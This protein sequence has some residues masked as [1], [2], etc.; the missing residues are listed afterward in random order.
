MK[1]KVETYIPNPLRCFKC[2][3]FRH[4]QDRCTRPPVCRRCGENTWTV[5][6][7]LF[8]LTAEKNHPA[9][10]RDCEVWKREK[11]IIKIK[12]TK[13]I[14]FPEARKMIEAMKYSEMSKRNIPSTNQQ[15]HQTYENNKTRIKPEVITQLINE[16]RRLIQ[17]MK[18][19]IRSHWKQT[20]LKRKYKHQRFKKPW[21][22]NKIKQRE[23]KDSLF[24]SGLYR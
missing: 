12:Y 11:D 4:H 24:W 17:E 20:T 10:S 22:T 13:N 16:M 15:G 8:V 1:I 14:T 9:N 23:P 18:T 2:Q 19:I 7:K 21:E 3:R 5:K 6:R